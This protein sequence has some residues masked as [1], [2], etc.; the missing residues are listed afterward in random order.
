MIIHDMS[1]AI[2][3]S[4]TLQIT[5]GGE[6]LSNKFT[7][8]PNPANRNS[9][10]SIAGL[11]AGNYMLQITS[12]NGKMISQSNITVAQANSAVSFQTGNLTAGVYWI[13]ATRISG[14]ASEKR[15]TVTIWIQ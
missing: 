12:A 7:V 11:P 9:K 10:Q 3:Y 14:T 15:L 13:T 4:N 5:W 8:F 2:H 6:D 1:G